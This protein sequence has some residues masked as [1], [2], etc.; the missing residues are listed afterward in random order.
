MMN[1][2]GF[3]LLKSAIWLSGFAMVYILFLRNERFFGLIRIFLITGI[4]SAFILPLFTVSYKVILAYPVA[5]AVSRAGATVEA[6]TGQKNFPFAEVLLLSVYFA[7]MLFVAFK[8]FRQTRFMLRAIREADNN[9]GGDTKLIRTADFGSSFSFFSWIFVNPSVNE[10]EMKEIMNHEMVH[11][12]HRHWLDLILAELLCMVQWFNPLTWLYGRLIRQNHEYIADRMALQQTSDPAVYRATLLN[13]IVGSQVISLTNSFSYSVNKKRFVMMQ[14]IFSPPYRKLKLLLILPVFSVILFAF[15]RPDYQYADQQGNSPDQEKAQPGQDTQIKGKILSSDGKP[16]G[17]ANIIVKNTTRGTVTDDNG[18]FLIRDVASN[19]ELVVSYVGFKTKVIKAAF[20]SRSPVMMET[21]TIPYRGSGMNAPPPPPPPPAPVDGSVAPPP[22]IVIDGK[23]SDKKMEQIDPETIN[24]ISVLKDK[25]AVEK[26]GAKGKNGVIEIVLKDKATAGA[27]S[28][29]SGKYLKI[30]KD[31]YVA[32]EDLPKFPEGQSGLS[33]FLSE[34]L[35]YP[36]GIKGEKIK[37]TVDV[38]FLVSTEGKLSQIKVAKSLHPLL[39]AEAV[40]VVSI[41]PD[42]MPGHQN[43]KP[44]EVQMK[45][46]IEF[47]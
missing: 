4:L 32:V 27:P 17:G 28:P 1:A 13:Q 24:E 19:A 25:K 14:N 37:G 43:G 20:V 26:Y 38:V 36:E 45:L 5:Q 2:L 11:I 10:I 31:E 3:Y 8:I 15:A 22:L 35:K 47:K 9:A 16:L 12:R 29:G 21:D 42:W 7:G 39:D 44:V 30:K 33:A 34:N 46:A 23:I 40:R 18:D 6:V 41:M